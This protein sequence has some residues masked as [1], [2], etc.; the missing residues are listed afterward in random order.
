MADHA[1]DDA[2]AALG[3]REAAHGARSAAH[4]AESALNHVGGAHFLPLALGNREKVQQ[5]MQIALHAGHR[6]RPARFPALLPVMKS[7]L[8]FRL[9]PGAIDRGRAG[10]TRAKRDRKSTRLNSSH[11]VSS[12]A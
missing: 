8:R 2:V 5:A 3:I 4:F 10:H 1:E 11:T 7:L 6:F 9:A 12:Y